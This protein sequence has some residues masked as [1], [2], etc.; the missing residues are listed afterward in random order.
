[1]NRSKIELSSSRLSGSLVDTAESEYGLSSKAQSVIRTDGI[2]LARGNR[3]FRVCGVTYGP[4]APNGEG[5]H[6]P[7]VEQVRADFAKMIEAG[8][9]SVRTYHV[10]PEWFFREAAE[11]GLYLLVDIPWP[12]HLCFLDSKDAQ[13]MGR[14]A[15]RDAANIGRNHSCVLAYSVGNEIP[16][17]IVRWHGA[18]R[19]E[20]YL[21]ELVDSVHQIHPDGLVTYSNYPSTEYL[22]LPFLDL[23]TFNVYLL[24]TDTFRNYLFRLQN[25]IG[26]KPLLLGEIGMDT[27]SHSL[28]EQAVFLSSHLR[29]L[30]LMGLAGSFVFAWTDDWFTGG[31]QIED[32]TFGIT[33]ADRSPKPSLDAVSDVYRNSSAAMLRKSPRVSVVVCSYN[34]A[35]TLDECLR[36][37]LA[38]DYPDYEVILVDDG[39]TDRTREI[40]AAF[41]SVNTIHQ[42][43][44]GLSYA[45][46]MSASRPPPV[47]LWRYTGLRSCFAHTRNG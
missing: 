15:V 14:N 45:S 4:F 38:L 9:N 36:S 35:E 42:P 13:R 30:T 39:S 12:K 25:R 31:F 17:N 6:F 7:S 27:L 47:R 32:W 20:R 16:A 34:G 40:S 19:V 23:A 33:T 44:Q 41:T 22:E 8:V 3:S 26:T 29:E 2:S 43:N 5:E 18:K 11:T 1:M 46:A 24:Y 37:L 21:S 28:E 10:P